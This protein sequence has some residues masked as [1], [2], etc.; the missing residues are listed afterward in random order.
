MVVPKFDGHPEDEYR[1]ARRNL[2][3]AGC[4]IAK[5]NV[6]EAREIVGLAI[7][8]KECPTSSEDLIYMDVSNWGAEDHARAVE[9]QAQ[10][11]LF[12]DMTFTKVREQEFPDVTRV[13]KTSLPTSSART[14]KIGRNDPCLCGSGKKFKK[15][16]LLSVPPRP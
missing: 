11:G 1:T 14:R 7:D 16:C 15:C 6:P 9:L 3:A 12:T 4:S 8:P 13:A 10:T 2:L 5:L